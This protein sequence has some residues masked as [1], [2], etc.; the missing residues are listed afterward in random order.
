MTIIAVITSYNINANFW[1][2]LHAVNISNNTQSAFQW[3]DQ[4]EFN[5]G[6]NVNQTIYPWSINAQNTSYFYISKIPP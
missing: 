6:N 4:T 1:I 5:Y 2:G 3:S